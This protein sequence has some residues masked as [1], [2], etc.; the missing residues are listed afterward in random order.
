MEMSQQCRSGSQRIPPIIGITVSGH[1]VFGSNHDPNTLPN[2][3]AENNKRT[4][5]YGGKFSTS[6][7][8]GGNQRRHADSTH[9]QPL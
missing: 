5:G 7:F 3:P 9:T 1:P 8:G 6:P 4:I 2:Q